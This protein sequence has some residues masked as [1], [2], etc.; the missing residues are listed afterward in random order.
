MKYVVVGGGTAGWLTALYVKKF[1][2]YSEV[3][4]IASSEIGVLG[5]GEG[6]TPHFVKF[7]KKID[8][9]INEIFINA[10]GTVKQGIKFVNWNGNGE[11]FFHSFFTDVEIPAVH[12]DANLLAKYLESVAV[13]R[14]ITLIDDIVENVIADDKQYIKGFELKSGTT[15][16]ANFVFDCS[17]LKRLIIGKFYKSNWISYSDRLPAKK[18]MPFFMPNDNIDLPKHT[19]AIAMK[20]G[21][22]WKIPVQ[23]RYGCGYV[24]D[25]NFASEDDILLEIKEHVGYE[26]EVPRTF[27]FDA[28]CYEKI[29]INNCIAI[30]LSAGFTEPLEATSIWIFLA[31][32]ESLEHKMAG[33]IAKDKRSIRDFNSMARNLNEEISIFLHF[34][35]LTKRTDSEFWKT[36][37]DKNTTPKFISALKDFK[38]LTK[39][40]LDYLNLAFAVENTQ[41]RIEHFTLES[42]EIVANG[43]GFY[44]S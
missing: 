16:K 6:T 36:F 31:I 11:S 8:I 12:F 5:A 15:I 23:G 32:L 18:A 30:G 19:E 22:I 17:G 21:W 42:W 29:W 43:L 40:D 39:R 2:P 25:S 7:L 9:D 20:H 33:I 34:H 41:Q 38:R 3:T 4:V 13:S 14:G 37:R 1:I 44:E 26:V 27:N 10:K 28:G 35:Y 24:F